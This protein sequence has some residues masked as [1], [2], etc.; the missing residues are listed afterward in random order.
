MDNVSLIDRLTRRVHIL[1]TND[2][3]F[4]LQDSIHRRGQRQKAKKSQ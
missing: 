1:K 2:E 3:I 4:R